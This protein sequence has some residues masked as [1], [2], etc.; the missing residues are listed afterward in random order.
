ML[1]T[2]SRFASASTK[3]RSENAPLQFDEA[4]LQMQ[5]KL[6]EGLI[7]R[8]RQLNDLHHGLVTEAALF[9]DGPVWIADGSP[10]AARWIADHLD[11]CC[12]TAREWIRVG[13]ALSE[14][15]ATAVAFENGNLSFAK[16]RSIT[17]IATPD[18]ELALLEIA[19]RVPADQIAKALAIW[20]THN[21]PDDIID[22]RQ[23][24]SRSVRWRN[25]PDGTVTALMRFTPLAAGIMQAAIDTQ[26]MRNKHARD[27]DGTWPTV[28]NRRADAIVELLTNHMGARRKFEVILHVRG[29]GSSLDDGTPITDSSVASLL[30][31]AFIRLL[32]HDAERRPVNASCLRRHPTPRQKRVVKERDRSCVECGRHDLLEYDHTPAYELSGRTHTDDL[33]IRCAPCHTAKHGTESV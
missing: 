27:A 3:R 16:V 25:E 20:S 29:D 6:A 13:R 33:K 22:A 31:E 21:E 9:A 15:R 5:R 14:L 19:E 23:H 10:S 18:N 7:G 17:R 32:I 12:A 4:E 11:V 2:H 28:A 8:G 24:A 30:P 1:E 26:M